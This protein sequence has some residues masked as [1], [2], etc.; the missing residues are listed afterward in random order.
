MEEQLT[1]PPQNTIPCRVK[2]TSG[3]TNRQLVRAIQEWNSTG[4]P[5]QHASLRLIQRNL[6]STNLFDTLFLYQP[7]SDTQVDDPLWTIVGRGEMQES[8]T[9]VGLSFHSISLSS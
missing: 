4:L 2:I 1:F 7:H 3:Q 5:W 6:Q 9:Q 8:K